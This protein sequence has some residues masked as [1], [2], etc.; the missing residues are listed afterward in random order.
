MNSTEIYDRLI[1]CAKS[2]MSN[3]GKAD[4]LS[5]IE[6]FGEYMPVVSGIA[7][8]ALYLLPNEMYF[9]WVKEVRDLGGGI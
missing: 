3:W 9:K 2:E 8:A 1:N 4:K 7:R 5:A 6:Q